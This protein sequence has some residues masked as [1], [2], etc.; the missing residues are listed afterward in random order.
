MASNSDRI[1]EKATLS[2]KL[3]VTSVMTALRRLSS[4]ACRFS[5]GVGLGAAITRG[6]RALAAVRDYEQIV[7]FGW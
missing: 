3:S 2:A 6:T 4:L 5:T 1:S 7:H